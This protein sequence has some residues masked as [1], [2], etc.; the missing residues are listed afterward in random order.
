[1]LWKFMAEIVI[2]QPGPIQ[3]C[4]KLNNVQSCTRSYWGKTPLGPRVKHSWTLCASLHVAVVLCL[5]WPHHKERRGWRCLAVFP[6]PRLLPLGWEWPSNS[7]VLQGLR[8]GTFLS[9]RRTFGM[10][11]RS[12]WCL[13]RRRGGGGSSLVRLLPHPSTNLFPARSSHSFS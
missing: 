5:D 7:L 1:M 13:G 4:W 6:N 12:F 9:Q 11:W 8:W 3:Y 2:T 10:W